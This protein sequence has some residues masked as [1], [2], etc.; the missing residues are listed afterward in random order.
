MD[1][2]HFSTGSG[3]PLILLHALGM[4][5]SAWR[6]VVPLLAQGRRL[7]IAS[8]Q[9]PRARR[10]LPAARHITL[11]GCGHVPMWDDPPSR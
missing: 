7:L 1:L 4:S 8:R 2:S 3:P 5:K 10:A 9:A 6:P 11:R